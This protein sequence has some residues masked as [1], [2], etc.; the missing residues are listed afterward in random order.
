VGAIGDAP[1]A[2]DVSG[3]AG[4]R[5]TADD[6]AGAVTEAMEGVEAEADL[7]A[8]AAY[9]RRAAAHLARRALTA[10]RDAAHR[11]GGTR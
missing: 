9:R 5:L 1:E 8:S 3:L 10:A 6:I 2:L 11:D 7:H 4:T